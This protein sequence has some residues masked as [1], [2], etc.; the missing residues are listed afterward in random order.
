L[1]PAEGRLAPEA[2]GRF[3]R[4]VRATT[5]LSHPNTVR[6]FDY[7]ISD[8]GIPYYA[9]EL[10]VGETLAHHVRRCGPVEPR[11]A[12]RLLSSVAKALAEAHDAGIVH[13]DIKPENLFLA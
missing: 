8:E 5:Q 4:E 10:L 11:R 3:E 12:V 9:M 13:R 2:L 7:G 1:R 6:I